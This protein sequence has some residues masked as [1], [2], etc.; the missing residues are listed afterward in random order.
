MLL[1]GDVLRGLA[2]RDRVIPEIEHA[3]VHQAPAERRVGENPLAARER[4]AWLQRHQRS[5]RHALDATGDEQLR[6]AGADATGGVVHRLEP[7]PAE[8]VHGHAG[9]ALGKPREEQ[10]HP[11]DVAV[12]LARLIRGAEDHLVDGV[13]AE[14]G[15]IDHRA[16]D[17]RREIVGS[18]RAQRSA[19]TPEGRADVAEDQRVAGMKAHRPSNSGRRFAANA[20]TPRA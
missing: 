18:D 8:T 5:S 13:V 1:P 17:V 9:H 16:D 6:L 10:G 2:E 14:I 4:F 3:R 19:V 12:V 20:L 15:P 11:A 7:A